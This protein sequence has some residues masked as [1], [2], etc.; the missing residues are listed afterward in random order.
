[1]EAGEEGGEAG[2]PKGAEPGE[3]V[4]ISQ[5]LHNISR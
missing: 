3:M 5:H 4:N 1:M 2:Y